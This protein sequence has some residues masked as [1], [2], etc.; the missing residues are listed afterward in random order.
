MSLLDRY[1]LKRFIL[2]YLMI[3]TSVLLFFVVIDVSANLKKFKKA[4]CGRSVPA[5]ADRCPRCNAELPDR[6][7]RC[8]RPS[9][10]DLL[11]SHYV[12]QV[13]MIYYQ[14]SP[15]LSVLAGMFV[16]ADLQG[17]HELIPMRTAGLS[18]F[19]IV[20]PLILMA[21]LLG[22]LGWSV[23]EHLIP[24]LGRLLSGAGLVDQE[25]EQF[26]EARA[27]G[28]GGVLFVGTYYLDSETMHDVCYQMLDGENRES[29]EIVADE[30]KWSEDQSGWML[31]RAV[32][33]EFEPDGRRR[34][35]PETGRPLV[36]ELGADASLPTEIEPRDL[37][38]AA[39]GFSSLSSA[40]LREQQQRLPHDESRLE[41]LL[42]SRIAYPFAGIVLLLLGLPFVLDESGNVWVGLL[43]CLVICSS[44]YVMTFVLLNLARYA[45]LPAAL[46]AW[47]PN[48]IYA[49]IGVGLML[50]KAK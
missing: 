8:V 38:E 9:A 24:R 31:S 27:D 48:M 33:L 40:E 12:R 42:Q 29:Y 20:Q 3:V 43:V 6:A 15:F 36:K 4:G 17:R 41:V 39:K 16:I 28:Q 14:M 30:A 1:V 44:Y 22:V 11:I 19:R 25:V 46:A 23:Q 5:G 32:R 7:R 21:I 18:T 10:R 26:P 34:L 45:V 47:L 50:V 37:R 35:D 13:P 2:S 49:P